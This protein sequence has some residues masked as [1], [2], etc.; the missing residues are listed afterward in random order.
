MNDYVIISDSTMDMPNEFTLENNIEVIPMD[1]ILDGKEY[2]NYLDY[3]EI[4][5]KDFYDHLR[6]GARCSTSQISIQTTIDTY[7]KYLR[8]GKDILGIVF[9]SGLS[10]SFNSVRLACSELKEKYPERTI[11]L[12]DSKCASSGEGLL[13]WYANEFKKSGLSLL[14]CYNKTLELVNKLCHW[15]TVD[16]IDT[17]RRGGR[18][19][20]GAAFAA[21]TLNIKPVLH[22]DDDGHLIPIYKKIGRKSAIRAIVNSYEKLRDTTIKQMIIISHGD[23]EDDA[24]YLEGEIKKITPDA[25]F[26]ISKIGPVIGAHSGPGTLALFF[27]GTKR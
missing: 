26:M 1:F 8:D 19:S 16:D 2:K 27:I 21:K 4:D 12:I 3:R 23:C 9:S 22:V 18:V 15:F 5:F 20:G 10:G 17:L 24:K 25:S 7:E 14:D 13:V 6:K 11:M